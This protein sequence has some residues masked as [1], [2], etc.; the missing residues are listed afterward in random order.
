MN[1]MTYKG[2][3]GSVAYSEKDNVFFGKI[4]GINGLVNFEGESVKELTA[5]FHEAVDDYVAANYDAIAD[6]NKVTN[7]CEAGSHK[8]QDYAAFKNKTEASIEVPIGHFCEFLPYGILDASGKPKKS[9][10]FSENYKIVLKLKGSADATAEK[11]D[12]VI[13]SFVITEPN[14]EL[15]EIRSSSIA[16]MIGGNGGYVT[17]TSGSGT[18]ATGTIS[19]NLGIWSIADAKK[20]LG[21]SV[22]KNAVVAA[23]IQGISAQSAKIDISGVL[24]RINTGDIGL[25]T[26]STDLY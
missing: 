17:S 7:S 2:Y 19:G 16:S 13:T 12:K 11:G 20:E 9:R 26:M 14:T 18:S 6:G 25:N 8:T 24:Y 3:L 15:P 22:T 1:T 5:A 10:L 4:E 23:S 21:V